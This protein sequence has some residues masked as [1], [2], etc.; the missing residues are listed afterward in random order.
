MRVRRILVIGVSALLV[1]SMT[2]I[3]VAEEGPTDD[4]LSTE[5]TLSDAQMRKA[6]MIADYFAPE[7][8]SEE[9]IA[10]SVEAIIELRT[11]EPAVG[12]GALYKL[13]LLSEAGVSIDE[14]TAEDGWGFGKYFKELREEDPD[15]LGDTPKNLGQLKKQQRDQEK[16]DKNPNR[17]K[18]KK[19]EG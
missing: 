4:G 8:A 17:G 11:G 3:A 14:M 9:D 15:W 2:S 19:Q 1:G 7:D 13:M 6:E 12:W 5:K 10:A 18:G 16:A